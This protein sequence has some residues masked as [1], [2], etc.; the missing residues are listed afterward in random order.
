MTR[1]SDTRPEFLTP[2]VLAYM[3]T[4][5]PQ[6]T[7][8]QKQ[9]RAFTTNC[10]HAHM[11]ISPLQAALLAWLVSLIGASQVL[12]L[13]MFTG[14]SALSMAQAMPEYGQL[15]TCDIDGQW[16]ANARKHWQMAKVDSRIGFRHGLASTSL[17]ALLANGGESSFDL[18]FIDADK[19]RYPQYYEKSLQLLRTG[20]IMVLD[21]V[22]VNGKVVSG[23][24]NSTS[25]QTLRAL[26]ARIVKDSRVRAITLPLA[27][28]MTLLTKST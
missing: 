7:S 23:G 26:N 15:I 9:L 6:E 11:Q 1:W 20:G 3:A 22:L 13:G 27:D 25:A 2:E 21:N 10:K 17:D 8:A 4:L 19:G 14:Y 16:H 18:I 28:G 12:E 5:L 24:E